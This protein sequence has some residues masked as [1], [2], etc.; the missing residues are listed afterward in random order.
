MLLA[1]MAMIAAAGS[2][3]PAAGA[4]PLC[5]DRLAYAADGLLHELPRDARPR[6]LGELPPADL[7][8]TVLRREDG[9]IV[10]VIVRYG[11]GATPDRDR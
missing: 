1:M 10:P 8:L 2:A 11:I 3:A 5:R 9:C 6:R 4:E 7:V